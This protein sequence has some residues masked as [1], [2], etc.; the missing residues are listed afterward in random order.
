MS[1]TK[2]PVSPWFKKNEL[3]DVAYSFLVADSTEAGDGVILRGVTV[4]QVREFGARLYDVWAGYA[5]AAKTFHEPPRTRGAPTNA[6]ERQVIPMEYY[7]RLAKE[8][9]SR[10]R[11][12][13]R[14]MSAKYGKTVPT[15]ER[16]A[17]ANQ[18]WVLAE[19]DRA[20]GIAELRAHLARKS[21]GGNRPQ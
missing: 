5:T 14:E 2:R 18:G 6:R 7:R 13:A 20:P 10:S 3:D 21:K 11:V 1:K 8:G 17:R 12:V 19:L 4:E 9:P 15:I 16:I